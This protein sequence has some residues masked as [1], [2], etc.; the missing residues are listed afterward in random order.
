[1][2]PHISSTTA[3]GASGMQGPAVQALRAQTDKLEYSQEMRKV[4]EGTK[5][6]Y[7]RE[8]MAIDLDLGSNDEVRGINTF[9][10]MKFR[11]AAVVLTTGTFMNGTIWVGRK[12]LPAGRYA[13]W[14]PEFRDRQHG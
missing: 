6:L 13:M 14:R 4:L 8:G 1:M 10:G 5:N 7:L 3:T 12:Q 11:A 9:F 2:Q